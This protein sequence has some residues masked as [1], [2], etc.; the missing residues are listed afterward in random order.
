MLFRKKFKILRKS[1]NI[2]KSL[3]IKL[4]N[5]NNKKHDNLKL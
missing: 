4:Y 2:K 1:I 5:A 3:I